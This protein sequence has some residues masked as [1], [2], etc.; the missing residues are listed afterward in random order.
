[1]LSSHNGVQLEINKRR[2]TVKTLNFENEIRHIYIDQWPNRKLKG[3]FK[4]RKYIEL[5][6]H[7]NIFI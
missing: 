2:K 6:E 7:E 1:M 3:K 5:N 4:K